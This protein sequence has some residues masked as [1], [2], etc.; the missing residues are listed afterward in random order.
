VEKKGKRRKDAI[1]KSGLVYFLQKY[2]DYTVD[3]SQ[4]CSQIIK[5]IFGFELSAS[6]INRVSDCEYKEEID[7]LIGSILQ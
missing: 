4:R 1:S 7:R 2:A 3:N 5:D 6:T